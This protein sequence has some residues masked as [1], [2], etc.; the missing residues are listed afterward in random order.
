MVAANLQG[1]AATI[2][3]L[4]LP[5]LPEKGDVSDFL[6]GFEDKA[7]AAERLAVLIEGAPLYQDDDTRQEE[8]RGFHFRPA[9]DLCAAPKPTNW[10]IKPFLDSRSLAELFGEAGGMKS[11]LVLDLGLS[12][13]SM[14]DWHGFAIHHPGPVFYIAGE[15]FSGLHRRIKAWADY[16]VADLSRVPFFASDRPARFLD[17]D[18]TEEV[19]AAVDELVSAHGTPVLVIIDTLN[20]N[21]GPGDEN[22]T[23]DM[24]RFIGAVD[25][26][27]SRYG[28]AVL[29]IH[30]SG[31]ASAERARGA[32]ALRAALD[33]EY[34]LQK[35]ADGSRT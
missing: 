18:G 13:A 12:I 16:H 20:R 26:L 30:H 25:R 33:W 32:S 6:A 3:W 15:G 35:N 27:R 24:T 17:Q 28:C 4:T 31:L 10:I 29:V 34:R 22:S 5:D 9:Y 2:K 7:E 11:F 1:H 21:F 8:R 23:A 14:I 19:L